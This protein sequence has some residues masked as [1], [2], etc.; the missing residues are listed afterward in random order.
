[1]KTGIELI[2]IERDE[3]LNKH[4]F[5]HQYT[6]EHPEYY[7]EGQL[8]V[9]AREMLAE[10]PHTDNFPISWDNA[11]MIEHMRTKPYIERLAIA[12]ALIAAEID[13]VNEYYEKVNVMELSEENY[14]EFMQILDAEFERQYPNQ[15]INEYSKTL[16]R[17][18]WLVYLGS[19]VQNIIDGEV[20]CWEED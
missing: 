7:E 10:F 18:G 17:D 3:Q 1:M 5:T 14:D 15:G 19:T 4:G 9:V 8:A 6:Y 16:N 2:S 13:R 11:D 20:E 12:G